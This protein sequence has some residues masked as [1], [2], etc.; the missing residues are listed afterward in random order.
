MLLWA[1]QTGNAEELA[2]D[3]A[4]Q[5]GD[6]QL[7][8]ALHSMD[9]FP[10][11]DLAKTRELLLITSTTGDGEP[12]DNGAGLW[13]AL[14]AGTPRRSSLTPA[15]P[16]SRLGTPTMT[17]SVVTDANSIERLAELG[18]TRIVDR[19]DCEP[20]YEDAAAGWLSEV[21]DELTRTPTPVG[22][23]RCTGDRGAQ[24]ARGLSPPGGLAWKGNL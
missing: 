24:R 11:A 19:V 12:P 6:A 4:A 13:R 21:I 18:A 5:L 15:T 7:P 23:C 22:G 16:F 10:I 3:V 17:T 1:S 2:A 9:D 14:S 20:D 8:V